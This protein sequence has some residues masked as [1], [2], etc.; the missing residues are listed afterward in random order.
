ML[1]TRGEAIG[2]DADLMVFKFTMRNGDQIVQ[3]QISHAA[4]GDLSWPLERADFGI[5]RLSLRRIA[6]LSKL[7]RPNSS[8]KHQIKKRGWSAFLRNTFEAGQGRRDNE[9]TR[10]A[11]GRLQRT[12]WASR[13]PLPQQAQDRPPTLTPILLHCVHDGIRLVRLAIIS[14][15]PRVS[16]H[17]AKSSSLRFFVA[18]KYP[19]IHELISICLSAS[20]IVKLLACDQRK[21]DR[22]LSVGGRNGRQEQHTDACDGISFHEGSVFRL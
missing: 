2:Y 14:N 10:H 16:F 20:E 13:C 3:C 18:L 22:H 8:T 5:C 7:W 12:W 1:L 4:L 15:D 21:I 19:L 9:A 11:I 17:V 6:N